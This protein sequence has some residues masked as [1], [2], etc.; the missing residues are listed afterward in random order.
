MWVSFIWTIIAIYIVVGLR[1]AAFMHVPML[2]CCAF[3]SLCKACAPKESSIICGGGGGGNNRAIKRD[4]RDVPSL[5]TCHLNS[6][7]KKLKIK[8]MY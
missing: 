2:P 3:E 4:S 1:E 7:E 5:F 6:Y 8:K